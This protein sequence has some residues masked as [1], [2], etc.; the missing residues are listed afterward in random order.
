MYFF[1]SKL[2]IKGG[3]PSLKQKSVAKLL[4]LKEEFACN[5]WWKR[6]QT[7]KSYTFRQNH[8]SGI[9][10]CRLDHTFISNKLQEFSNDTDI[11]PA[12]KTD[13]S[14]VLVTISNYN[15]FKPGPGLWKF[16]NSL[17]KDETFTNTFKNFIQ[18]MINELNTNTSLSN[19]LKL[20]LLKYKSED[21]QYPIASNTLKKMKQKKSTLKIN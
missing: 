9:T 8:S 4:D 18:N 7:K 19:Q 14:S 5:I 16:N 21:L 15:F 13:H 1:N 2:E 12:F 20:E 3:K 11:I 6:N 17:T 10:N